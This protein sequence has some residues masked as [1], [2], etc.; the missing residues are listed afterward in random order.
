M[1]QNT[2]PPST[3]PLS[4]PIS[5]LTCTDIGYACKYFLAEVG[6]QMA[7]YFMLGTTVG[8][9]VWVSLW[10]AVLLVPIGAVGWHYWKK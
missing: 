4:K 6:V 9:M 5:Q 7:F 3:D 1:T 2:N 10:C 8:A